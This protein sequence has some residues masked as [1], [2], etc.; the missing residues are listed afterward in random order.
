MQNAAVRVP[1]M[2]DGCRV[3]K[4]KTGIERGEQVSDTAKET[5]REIAKLHEEAV[6]IF[7][8]VL[9]ELNRLDQSEAAIAHNARAILARLAHAN[10]LLERYEED[11]KQ[12]DRTN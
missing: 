7:G 11:G 4:D 8:A 2:Q 5:L 12:N 3:F 10:I 1:W 6:E 9:H